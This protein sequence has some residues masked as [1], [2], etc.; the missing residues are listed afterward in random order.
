MAK[1]DAGSIAPRK[2]ALYWFIP[3]FV[4]S[5]VGSERGTT[6]DEGTRDSTV[7]YATDYG[8]SRDRVQTK[9]MFILLKVLQE[10]F[11]HPVCGPLNPNRIRGDRHGWGYMEGA[12]QQGEAVSEDGLW[13]LLLWRREGGAEIEGS[14]SAN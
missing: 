4:K 11:T 5:K 2:M 13:L 10:R 1:S 6:E 7:R 9:G 12:K 14:S 3:A 8:E